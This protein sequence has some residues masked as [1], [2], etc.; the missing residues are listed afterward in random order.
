MIINIL[1]KNNETVRL[2]ILVPLDGIASYGKKPQ[3]D[4]A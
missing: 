4:F 1:E 2:F 3:C